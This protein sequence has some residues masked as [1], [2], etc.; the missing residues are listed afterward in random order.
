MIWEV[1]RMTDIVG[2][3]VASGFPWQ[4]LIF[5]ENQV[6]TRAADATAFRVAKSSV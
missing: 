1:F 6:N 2:E 5:R 3:S 4:T